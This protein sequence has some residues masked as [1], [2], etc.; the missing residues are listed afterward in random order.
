MSC[1]YS[2]RVLWRFLL[3]PLIDLHFVIVVFSNHTHLLLGIT[4]N[5]SKHVIGWLPHSLIL[6][7]VIILS[8]KI[9]VKF[10]KQ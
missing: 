5:L 4:C 3:V 1:D 8:G 10:P 9:H 2:T 7:T 6:V